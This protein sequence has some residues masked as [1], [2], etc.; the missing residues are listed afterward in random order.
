MSALPKTVVYCSAVADKAQHAYFP[1]LV[2]A[3]Q[4][5]WFSKDVIY[6]QAIKTHVLKIRC[7]G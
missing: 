1:K 5:S 7:G 2:F 4:T 3:V 6:F